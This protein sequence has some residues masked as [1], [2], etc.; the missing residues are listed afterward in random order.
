MNSL[1]QMLPDAGTE[2]ETFVAVIKVIGVG[3]GGCN[4][5]EHMISRQSRGIT[6]IAA[7][8]DQQ[9]LNKSHAHILIPLG[10]TGLGAGAKPEIGA[11]AAEQAADAIREALEGTNLLFITAGMGGGT[12]TGAA[13]VIARIARSM[14]ILTVGVVTKPF[15]Y[16]G[17]RRMRN[18]EEGIVKLNEQVDSL[19]II[20]NDKLE[21]E[22]GGA[23]LM[24]DCFAAANDVLYR[25]CNGIAEI[26]HTPGLINVDYEDLRT[27]MSARGTALMGLATAEGAD[28]AKIAS[29]KAIACP[30]LEGANLQGAMGLLVYITASQDTM[31]QSEIRQV[32]SIMRNFTSPDATVVF[33]TAF[34]DSMGDKLRVTVVATGIAGEVKPETSIPTVAAPAMK[35]SSAQPQ[36]GIGVHGIGPAMR[37][38]TQPAPTVRSFSSTRNLFKNA[39]AARPSQ[40]PEPAAPVPQPEQRPAPAFARPQ[41]EQRPA[42]AFARPQPEQRPAPAFARPQPEQRPAPAF[43]SPQPAEPRQMAQP[44]PAAAAEPRLEPRFSP[45]Q[46]QTPEARADVQKP[47]AP[48]QPEAPKS[49]QTESAQDAP[50]FRPISEIAGPD[51]S[52]ETAERPAP[53]EKRAGNIFSAVPSFFKRN[54]F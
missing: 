17:S 37:T 20:L 4:A 43:A 16:E 32:M 1:I 39:A 45:I 48:L 13:P 3:G 14:G 30:L 22:V 23:A 7:N 54:R 47:S 42:P 12:G 41:P 15:F 11:A 8:T 46:R 38:S 28:R 29:E 31:T 24:T 5:V 35:K 6:F 27:V 34:D 10:T 49:A 33:G 9:V 52:P 21:D 44:Q 25:A 19:I 53:E 50:L 51:Q 36:S 26:I 40:E 18:A 2:D